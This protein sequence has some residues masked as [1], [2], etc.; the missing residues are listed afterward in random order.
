VS[1]SVSVLLGVKAYI[2]PPFIDDFGFIKLKIAM[3]ED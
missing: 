1:V 3:R 2:H